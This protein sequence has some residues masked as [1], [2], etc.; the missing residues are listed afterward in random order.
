MNCPVCVNKKLIE[1]KKENVLID[2]CPTCKG[3]WLDRGE[4]ETIVKALVSE[5]NTTR[6]HSPEPYP[7]PYKEKKKTSMLDILGDLLL[8]W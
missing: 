4:L 1:I 6:N 2:I 5:R 8:F 7:E 3:I